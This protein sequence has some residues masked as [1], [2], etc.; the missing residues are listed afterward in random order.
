[1][2][3]RVNFTK[4]ILDAIAL[5]ESGQRVSVLDNKTPGL[6]LRVTSTG[7]KTFCVF[8]RVRGGGNP[9]RVTLGRYPVM[10]IDQA[11]RRAVEITSAMEN[12]TNP[13]EVIRLKKGELTFGE[14]FTD[15]LERHAKPRK[16][17]WKGDEQRYRQYLERS[18]GAKKLSAINRQTIALIHSAIS[19]D[20]HPV[21]ANRVLALISS[22]F[23]RGIEWGLIENNP[24]KGVRRNPETSRDRFLQS[25][26]LPRFFKALAEEPNQ[27]I[28]DYFLLSLL[29]GARRSNVLAMRWDEISLEDAIWRIPNTK[30]GTSQN[31][32]L[33]P[34][35]LEILNLR[36]AE[37]ARGK[38]KRSAFV[39]PS[40]G[41]SGHLM[42]PKK[43]WQRIFDRDEL[44]Q[45]TRMIHEVTGKPISSENTETDDTESLTGSLDD[46]RSLAI[47]LKIDTTSAR[48]TGL[49]VH[50]LRRTLGSWQAK[51]GAS[52]V[53]IGK[54]LN[55]KNS[56]TTA[57]YARLDL[58]PV[59]ASMERATTAML[60]AGNISQQL[61]E[62]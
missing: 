15:F 57:I 56:A 27:T 22:I 10:T 47:E 33:L 48:I 23:G 43:G 1:M 6:Q 7:V 54:S 4:A 28:K 19:K 60:S 62:K 55:H 24:A 41:E 32:P 59:R 30:N 8:R 50:D 2:S 31:V 49:R 18:L 5:P 12:G 34:E 38:A 45:L 14:L 37:Q 42:E 35:A 9:E 17:T 11:R 36:K 29:T 51:T 21:V 26:E 13:A 58:D 16:R 39:F 40:Y 61:G 44:S 3:N 25:D 20:G 46:A 53:I 52:L